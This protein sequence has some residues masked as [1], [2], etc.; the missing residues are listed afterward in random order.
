MKTQSQS[1]V[2]E[3]LLCLIYL[4]AFAAAEAV[5]RYAAPAV[6]LAIYFAILISLIVNSAL[7]QNRGSGR[8]WLVLALVPLI[9]IVGLTIPI[10]E[11]SKIYWYFI[12]AVPIFAGALAV[13]R[14]LKVNFSDIGFNGKEPLVQG[15]IAPVGLGLGIVDYLILR[16]QALSSGLSLPT[17]IIP[18]LIL[19]LSTGF[20]EEL[21]FRG[22]LQKESIALGSWGWVFVA[23]YYAI[24]QLGNGSPLQAVFA[25][26]V[27][28]FY[29]WIVKRTGSIVGVSLSHGLLNIGVFLIFPHML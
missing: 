4:L 18:A 9:R 6:G 26:G 20:L 8:L 3:D 12:I 19:L 23:L 25:F 10:A 11:I 27:A 7:V 16:P 21:V 29:G 5:I 13:M 2:L 17:L 15:L 22:L 24:I 1:I 14:T 28:L